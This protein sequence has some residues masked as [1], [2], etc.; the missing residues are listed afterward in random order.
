MGA[1][2]CS[3]WDIE[4]VAEDSIFGLLAGTDPTRAD[5][6]SV[7]ADPNAQERDESDQQAAHSG[8]EPIFTNLARALGRRV[9]PAGRPRRRGRLN[10]GALPLRSTARAAGSLVH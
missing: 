2:C 10:I 9:T 6:A 3:S 7:R 5:P 8:A 1:S 4:V